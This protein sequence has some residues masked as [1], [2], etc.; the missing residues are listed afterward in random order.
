[1]SKSKS[2]NTVAAAV[3][4][5]AFALYLYQPYF[6]KFDSF[7]YLHVL[8]A[9]LASLGCFLL[10]RRWVHLFA[11]SFFAGAVYG[12]AP[13]MLGLGR[14]HSVGGFLAAAV[15]WLFLPAAYA[16]R[17]KQKWLQMPLAAVPFAAIIGFFQ[18]CNYFRLFPV[19]TQLRLRLADLIY[20]LSPFVSIQQNAV[21]FGFYHIPPAAL[22]LGLCMLAAARRV[23]VMVILTAGLVAAYL[24]VFNTPAVIWLAIPCVCCAIMIGQGLEAI[25]LAGFS[26]RRW[27]LLAAAVSGLLSVLSAGL[28]IHCEKIIAGIGENSAQL[29]AD[30]AMFYAFGAVALVVIF[31][32]TR[33][34]VR[35]RL[36]RQVILSS[37]VG[38]DIFIGARFIIDGLF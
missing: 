28:V 12:F 32:M 38:L 1:M 2:L 6:E 16:A 20:N 35:G 33:A 8:N 18:V 21:L 26:D 19:P 13:F 5:A 30:T 4:Y 10:S 34:A 17:S 23:G 27:I 22:V 29:F 36:I 9:F 3:F 7:Q 14:F 31:F 11:G 15:P 24:A 25:T 37:A